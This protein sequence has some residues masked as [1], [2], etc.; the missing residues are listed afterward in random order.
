M[1]SK[2]ILHCLGPAANIICRLTELCLLLGDMCDIHI[3]GS[4]NEAHFLW[5]VDC[6]PTVKG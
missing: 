5:F 1:P 2:R 6:C 3:D 4:W